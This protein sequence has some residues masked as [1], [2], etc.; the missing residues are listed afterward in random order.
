MNLA[1]LV[2]TAHPTIINLCYL[3]AVSIAP[4]RIRRLWFACRIP[5][6]SFRHSNSHFSLR[7]PNHYPL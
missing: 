7:F 1:L 6:S 5:T 4:A 3:N 2:G